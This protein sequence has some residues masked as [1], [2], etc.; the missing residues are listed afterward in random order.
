MD[1]LDNKATEK[2]KEGGKKKGKKPNNEGLGGDEK[3]I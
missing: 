3:F 2:R 1:V